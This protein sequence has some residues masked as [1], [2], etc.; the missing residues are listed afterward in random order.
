MSSKE[1]EVRARFL[2]LAAVVLAAC[3]GDSTGSTEAPDPGAE[4]LVGLFS[5]DPGVCGGDD[6]SGSYFRMVQSGGNPETGP[7][8]DNGDSSCADK[9]WSTLE[10]GR[11]GGLITGSYQA[12][13]EPLFEADGT[14][15]ATSVITPAK[16]FAIGFGIST[17]EED[18]QTGEAVA[19]P[20]LTAADGELTGDL[21]A[22]SVS[23]NNQFFNQGAPKP[24]S[25]DEPDA[26]SGTYDADSGAYTLDWTSTIAG[27][28]FDG[29]S[30]IWHL[31][32][33]FTPT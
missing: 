9:T 10:P 1:P 6:A 18:P 29:F 13:A 20:S 33:T 4:Q 21:S 2:V 25:P 16:F 26:V 22:I 30:G 23:W 19:A 3:G 24:G 8:I 12:Q 17:N 27:G 11:D 28:P 15:T 7:F 31:E 14:S 5:I 32:G